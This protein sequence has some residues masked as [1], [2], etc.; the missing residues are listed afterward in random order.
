MPGH[1]SIA[2]PAA[3]LASGHTRA[4]Q[5]LSSRQR[6]ASQQRRHSPAACQA[7]ASSSLATV[8]SLQLS[9]LLPAVPLGLQL[10]FGL[11]LPGVDI[12]SVLG[13][14]LNNPVITVALAVGTYVFL[15]RLWRWLLKRVVAPVLLVAAIFF[16]AQH[17]AQTVFLGKSV[18]GCASQPLLD[19]AE[20]MRHW[21]L[22]SS[23]AYLMHT[24]L[25]NAMVQSLDR[26]LC[27]SALWPSA[28]W[29]CF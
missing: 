18:A 29:Q 25:Y 9:E 20:L 16:A 19:S 26:I 11:P 17:P 3:G 1:A 7:L 2:R 21:Q 28:A 12:L 15:P 24:W 27:W 23:L 14:L 8:S 6:I 5:V 22:C 13:F 4:T 10:P